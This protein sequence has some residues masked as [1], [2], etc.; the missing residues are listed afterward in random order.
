MRTRLSS[1]AVAWVALLCVQAGAANKVTPPAT[2]PATPPP[3]TPAVPSV[4]ADM[5]RVERLPGGPQL[6]FIPQRSVPM[7]SCTVLVPAGSVL[8][9]PSTN[10]AAHYLEHLLFNGTQTRTREQIYAQTDLLGAY[11]NAS[12]QAE[13][14]VFQ[15]LLPSER[16]R[17]GLALQADMLLHSTI[18]AD[19]FEKEKGIILEELAKDRTDPEY[20]AGVFE[21]KALW[22]EDPRSLP[23]LGTEATISAMPRDSVVAFYQARYRP[24][25]M[26][27]VVMGDF[28]VEQARAEIVRLYGGASERVAPLRA[29]PPFPVGRT[30]VTKHLAGLGKTRMHLMMPGPT[31]EGDGFAGAA[32]L[33]NL[34]SSGE[35]SAVRRAVEATGIHPLDASVSID[36]SSVLTI[37]VD[38]P[39]ETKDVQPVV[40]ALLA[41]LGSIAARG[42]NVSDRESSRRALLA[43]DISLREKM[44]YYGLMRADVLAL[45][46]AAALHETDDL[47]VAERAAQALLQGIVADGRVLVTACGDSVADGSATVGPVP[48][49]AAASWL[50]G[51]GHGEPAPLPPAPPRTT[52]TETKRIVLDN[53]LVVVAHASPDS[54]TFAAHVLLEDRA[55]HEAELHAPRGAVDVVQRMMGERT[56]KRSADELRGLLAAYG[57]TLKTTDIDNLPY[58]DYYFSPEY[59]YVR[60]ESIDLWGLAALELLDEV[61]YAPDFSPENFQKALDAAALR[62]DH[63][64]GT[65][66]AVAEASFYDALGTGHPLAGGVYGPADA[67]KHLDLDTAR[68]LHQAIVAPA[69]VI[70]TVSSNLPVDVIFEAAR[71][72]FGKHSIPSTALPPLAWTAKPESARVEKPVGREQSWIVVGAPLS[73][74]PADRLAVR[75]AASVLSDRLSERLREKEGLAYSIGATARLDGTGACVL[76]EAGT[77]AQNLDR[78]EKGMLEIAATLEQAPPGADD[79]EGVRNRSEGTERMRRLS[80]MGIAYAMAMAE[81]RGRDPTALDADVPRLRA[82]T[83][84]DVARVAAK[85]LAFRSPVVA[86]AR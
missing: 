68:R 53:G 62:A 39:V 48:G 50:E 65:P 6:V 29:R 20:D 66:R 70:L 59:S 60:L 35:Q 46:P 21:G 12:T 42:A 81:L 69:N 7:F 72:T 19:M 31:L 73:V 9:T 1:F 32:F 34:L 3:V 67:L 54:R 24:S 30:L 75:L 43:D 22:G 86:V 76:M 10:G 49:I 82:V 2:P 36:P 61:I 84:Q 18:P 8:E 55:R 78:M 17:D 33:E 58:D 83:P 5:A 13:R 77:R 63:D 25:G 79:L 26:T 45:D 80:R 23:V 51:G 64:A 47:A 37:A 27:I 74:D 4:P 57:A 16:W 56:A 52:R 14:T 44:H 15:L 28:D 11:N 41:H 40:N 85:Y 38:L 71:R